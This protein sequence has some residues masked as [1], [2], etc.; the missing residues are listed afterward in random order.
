MSETHSSPLH[1]TTAKHQMSVQKGWQIPEWRFLLYVN[2]FG[3]V[4]FRRRSLEPDPHRSRLWRLNGAGS[5]AGGQ[6]MNIADRQ[7]EQGRI[8][9]SLPRV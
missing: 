5:V 3:A 4:R 2:R 1:A 7:V 6:Q 9:R 8:D